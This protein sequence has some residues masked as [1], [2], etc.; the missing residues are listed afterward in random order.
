MEK[1]KELRKERNWSQMEL[2]RRSGVS[3]SF[4]NYL[5]AGEKQPTLTTLNKL[6][7]A[8]GVPISDLIDDDAPKKEV[9]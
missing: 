1:L 4:I 6:A 5:E 9:I 3:Q 8:F 2:S 7:K